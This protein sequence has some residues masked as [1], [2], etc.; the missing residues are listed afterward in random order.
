MFGSLDFL[1]TTT[2]KFRLADPDMPVATGVGAGTTCSTRNKAEKQCLKRCIAALKRH[3]NRLVAAIKQQA[4]EASPSTF[5]A[6]IG[7]QPT[8]ILDLLEPRLDRAKL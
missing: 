5:V 7:H 8:S 2:G 4:D 1:A 3:L 6:I